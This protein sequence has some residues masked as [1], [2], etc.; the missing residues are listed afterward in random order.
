MEKPIETSAASSGSSENGAVRTILFADVC[1]STQIYEQYGDVEGLRIVGAA[2]SVLSDVTTTHDG[3]VV[4]TIGDEVMSL[5]TDPSTA[6]AAAKAMHKAV[7][8]EASL[9]ER[10]VR[11]KVGLHCGNVLLEDD[12]VYGDAVNV[13]ARMVGLAQANQIIATQATLDH[14]PD[15]LHEN[16]RSLGRINVRGKEQPLQICEYLWKGDVAARTTIAGPF[17]REML[18]QASSK[19]LLEYG[20]EHITIDA[21]DASFTLGRSQENSLVIDRSCVS[22]QH[23]KIEFVNGF[24]VLT[25]RSTNGTYVRLG[26][27]EVVVHRDQIRLINEGRVRLGQ[28]LGQNDAQTIRFRC[29]YQR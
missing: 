17:Y 18:Q 25:D 28:A 3:K 26:D 27:E 7:L 6:C 9:S 5:F 12:D 19:L 29:K 24:F 10:D 15:A 13:A 2:V 21:D 1:K 20:G 8:D 16:M 4:K 11:V 14:L 23:A 22:R